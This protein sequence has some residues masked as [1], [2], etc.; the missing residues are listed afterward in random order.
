MYFFYFNFVVVFSSHSLAMHF[1][2][3]E[4]SRD[5]A[6][7]INNSS[8]RGDVETEAQ[9]SVSPPPQ[10]KTKLKLTASR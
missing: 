4:M 7:L 2:C 1:V 5:S 6:L 8:K 3:D 9:S 10:A